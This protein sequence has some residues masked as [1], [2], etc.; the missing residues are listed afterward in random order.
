[1]KNMIFSTSP[2]KRLTASPGAGQCRRPWSPQNVFHHVHLQRAENGEAEWN[3][4]CD[5]E[6]EIGETADSCRD[7]Q[8]HQ[9]P[10]IRAHRFS[11]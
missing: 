10:H 8:C 6:E 3:V 2:R 7:N 1:M 11:G 4:G 5:A 9:R